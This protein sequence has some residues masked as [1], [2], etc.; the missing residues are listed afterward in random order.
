M[1]LDVS[2]L[3]RNDRTYKRVLLRQSYRDQGK[4]KKRTLANLSAC[5]EAELEA[6]QL[7]LRHKQE[8]TQVS[9]LEQR[10]S[11]QQGPSVGAVWLVYTAGATLRDCPRPGP[12]TGGETG[13]VA[14]DRTGD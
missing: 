14:G 10:L 5:S 1:Y 13:A 7:A 12:I 9:S 4:V 6:L 3:Q 11:L 8:L 2:T